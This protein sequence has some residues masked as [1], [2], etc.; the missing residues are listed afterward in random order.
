MSRPRQTAGRQTGSKRG[1][2]REFCGHEK[3]EAPPAC[4][5]RAQGLLL[6]QMLGCHQQQNLGERARG[7]AVS[8]GV[9]MAGLALCWALLSAELGVTRQLG[10]LVALPVAFSAYLLISGTLGICAFSSVSGKRQADYGPEAVLDPES[11]SHLRVRALLAVAASL[12]IAGGFAFA[13]VSSS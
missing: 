5:Q 6:G 9:L 13:L 12:F 7:K 4:G 11:R 2:S 10:W 3:G 1:F 8:L